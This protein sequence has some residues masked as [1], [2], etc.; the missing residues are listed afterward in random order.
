L[1]TDK[2]FLIRGIQVELPNEDDLMNVRLVDFGAANNLLNG[3]ESPTGGVLA[4]LLETCTGESSVEVDLD[5]GLGDGRD[6][7]LGTFA[8]T[9]ES[10]GV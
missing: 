7:M 10:T 8:Q 6:G 3:F 5:G 2:S 4:E 9:A 1:K